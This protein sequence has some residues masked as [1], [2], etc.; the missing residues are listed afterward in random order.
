[1]KPIDVYNA[2]H[3]VEYIGV[4]RL[5]MEG[6]HSSTRMYISAVIWSGVYNPIWPISGNVEYLGATDETH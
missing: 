4:M 6:R 5:R 2:R 3:N 1:M